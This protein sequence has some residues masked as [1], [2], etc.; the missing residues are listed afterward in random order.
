MVVVNTPVMG[1]GEWMIPF[2][3]LA[4]KVDAILVMAWVCEGGR[5]N[6]LQTCGCQNC[7]RLSTRHLERFLLLLA[8]VLNMPGRA[9]R[10][11]E[12]LWLCDVV[13]GVS[14]VCDFVSC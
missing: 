12:T 2:L 1:G 6:H 14:V 7:F 3:E 11:Q 8:L 4:D 10:S 9:S 13:C 5:Q